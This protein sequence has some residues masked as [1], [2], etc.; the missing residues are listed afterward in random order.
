MSE[1]RLSSQG[2]W[3]S[4]WT[5]IA[6]ATGASVGL[7]NLW[8]FAYLAGSNGGG[9]FVFAYL[10]CVLLVGCPIMIAEV[11]IGSR[12]RGNPI[13]TMQQ[14]SHE[15]GASRY[16]QLLAWV[17][18]FAG[19]L[20]LSYYAVVASWSLTYVSQLLHSTDFAASTYM[21]GNWF[22]SLLA[23]TDQT[24]PALSGFLIATAF[25]VSLG[26]R[27]GIGTVMRVTLLLLITALSLMAV[28]AIQV[29]DWP[30]AAQFLFTFDLASLTPQ[31]WLLALGHAF[32]SLSIG[33]AAMM[34]FGAYVPEQRSI[35]MMVSW[36]VLF[37]VLLSVLAGLVIFPLVFS[38]NIE[39]GMGPGLV[40]V[41][42]P[43]AFSQLPQGE[44]YGALFFGVF[45]L[46]ALSS[47]VALFEPVVA[48][49]NER[50]RI[51]RPVGAAMLA[52]LIWL[53]SRHIAESLGL[54]REIVAGMNLFAL[55]DFVS[56]NILLPLGGLMV[57]L[58]VG[59]RMKRRVL[60]A[61]LRGDHALLF[62]LWH[63]VLRYIAPPAIVLVFVYSLYQ[64]FPV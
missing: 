41:A 35:T 48:G 53:L 63:G 52:G 32:F 2:G 50:F 30:A 14:I 51:W 43:Y 37:D 1:V 27:H 60:R 39:P 40:F 16:W 42:L 10:V 29:G 17:G 7:G 19:L 21:A 45:T 31:A 6:V 13:S 44:I 25:V 55:L 47:A 49:L 26:I 4:R 58:F 5:F 59:W 61:E 33:V 18:C 23:N 22:N 11:V 8:K 34:A 38:F 3:R 20:I 36:V 54:G 24:L 62:S 46:V 56:V 57:A 64:R 12:G 28:Y 15:A 9:A